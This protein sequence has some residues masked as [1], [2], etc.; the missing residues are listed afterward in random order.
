VSVQ[1]AQRFLIKP[2]VC[3]RSFIKPTS[4][5]RDASFCCELQASRDGFDRAWKL[6]AEK[7]RRGDPPATSAG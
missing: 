2:A 4:L 7:Q 1:E 3:V 6:E 5:I